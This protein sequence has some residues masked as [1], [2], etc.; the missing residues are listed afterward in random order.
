MKPSV[1]C[2]HRAGNKIH[3]ALRKIDIK[4]LQVVPYSMYGGF[5]GA[6]RVRLCFHGGLEGAGER[7]LSEEQRAEYPGPCHAAAGCV[8]SS[9]DQCV[10]TQG[11]D[12]CSD[13]FKRTDRTSI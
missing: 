9:S 2:V 11:G 13:C 12:R 4:P 1:C 7:I 5:E 3:D 6:E 10:Q 8:K